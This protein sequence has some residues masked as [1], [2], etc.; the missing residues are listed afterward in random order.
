MTTT[1]TSKD[2][3]VVSA[4]IPTSMHER[5]LEIAAVRGGGASGVVMRALEMYFASLDRVAPDAPGADLADMLKTMRI[6]GKARDSEIS[7]KLESVMRLLSS[8]LESPTL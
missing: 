4:R 3:A 8:A 6:E 5:V 1:D 2:T 7:R